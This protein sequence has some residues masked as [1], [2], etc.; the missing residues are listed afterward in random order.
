MSG[1]G[2]CCGPSQLK[3]SGYKTSDY[4]SIVNRRLR[5]LDDS[6]SERRGLRPWCVPGRL[7]RRRRRCSR[8]TSCCS[9][10]CSCCCRR[11]TGRCSSHGLLIF[12]QYRLEHFAAFSCQ[13]WCGRM[14]GAVH[15]R[16]QLASAKTAVMPHGN[17]S[18]DFRNWHFSDMAQ[19]PA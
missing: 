3:E 1:L 9:S 13:R 14:S 16:Q 17:R 2:A 15:E 8:R 5:C 11:S 12:L 4:P 6:R 10:C 18:N 19:C 7:C